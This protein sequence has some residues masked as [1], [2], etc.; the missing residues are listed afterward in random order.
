VPDIVFTIAWGLWGLLFLG[1]EGFTLW[2]KRKGDTLSEQI[3]AIEHLLPVA[4]WLTGAVLLWLFVHFVFF[5]R[6]G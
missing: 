1:L 4:R 2:R 3:W 6:F 5:G